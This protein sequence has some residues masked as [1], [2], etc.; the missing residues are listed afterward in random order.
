MGR[1]PKPAS[2]STGNHLSKT[3]KELFA[4]NEKELA[5]DSERLK[6]GIEGLND[7]E[8]KRFESKGAKDLY[9]SLAKE[10]STSSALSNNHIHDLIDLA[11]EY[12][13][14]KEYKKLIRKYGSFVFDGIKFSTN[15]AEK[16]RKDSLKII[17]ELKSFLGLSTVD[18][19]T[20]ARQKAE[21]NESD[22]LANLFND[23]KTNEIWEEK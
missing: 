2:Q 7:V 8:L 16:M 4:K 11:N 20:L 18:I 15:P 17:R 23:D 14:L 21:M 3:E 6:K 22:S 12:E 5:G 19:V 10:A 13:K 9:D 1:N